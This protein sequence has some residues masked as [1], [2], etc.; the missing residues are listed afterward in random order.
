M[1]GLV[2]LALLLSI[3]QDLPPG[4]PGPRDTDINAWSFDIRNEGEQVVTFLS[5]NV[6]VKRVDFH[7]TAERAMV[8]MREGSKPPLEEIYAEGNVVYSNGDQELRAERLYFNF[9]ESK[10]YIVEL[11][12]RAYSEEYKQTLYLTASEARMVRRGKF[13]ARDVKL[14][15]CDY[16]I[17][18]YHLGIDRASLTGRDEY[19]TD[20]PMILWPYKSW[21]IRM[22]EILPEI[23]GG[24]PI[25]FIPGLVVG[26]WVKDFPVR[27]VRYGRTSRFGSTVL[28]EMERRL[29]IRDKE[30]K[31]R[32]WGKIRGQADWREK[33][34]GGFGLDL[35][36]AWG[37]YSGFIDTYFLHD[38]GRDPDVSFNLK[39]PPLPRPE[40]GRARL[41]HRHELG[42]QWRV[43]VEA[44]YLT[45]RSLLEEFFEKEF[46][47]GKVPETAGYVRWLDGGAGAYLYER[48]RLNDFQTQNE[49]LPRAI[50]TML[51][52]P[53]GGG[54]A[55]NFL[56]TTRVE[57]SHLRRRHDKELHIPSRRQWRGDLLTEISLPWDLDI[58][59]FMPFI[60]QRLTLFEDDLQGET[61]FRSLWST[62]ARLFAQLHGTFPDVSWDLVGLDGLRHVVD[63]DIRYANTVDNNVPRSTLFRFDE[64][65][66][67]GEFEEAAFGMRHRFQTR[68]EHGQ[69]FEFFSIWGEV[70][71]YPD[72]DR[73]TR[74]ANPNSYMTPFHWILVTP[75][76][77]TGT[78]PRRHWSNI[79]WGAAF[80]PRNRLQFGIGGEYNPVS[81]HEETR[82]MGVT[83]MPWDDV[84]ASVSHAFVRGLTDAWNVS[85]SLRMTE[86][87]SAGGSFQYDFQSDEVINQALVFSRDYHDFLIQVVMERDLGRDE[88]RVYVS[89][90]PK[91]LGGN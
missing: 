56:V 61:G 4:V 43:E 81:G 69:S 75:E 39:F 89:F 52:R 60:Q 15:T 30:G 28:S 88:R 35:E 34:G 42:E 64:L 48:H 33:R 2:S 24:A 54:F 11:K 12:G 6:S 68:D 1:I 67:L 76:L 23:V 50:F 9:K 73:D 72:S 5:G 25:F 78:F 86:K 40:R 29:R 79:H 45:D 46:K 57:I 74:R 36:Y 14:T 84:Q 91:F 32:S 53:L 77:S 19:E 16:G 51:P 17:P 58:V 90:V 8:W 31:E 22:E 37:P 38:F 21:D 10:A 55:E 59:Q 63:L 18:H 26:S 70:E 27:S 62:G 85:A 44:S 65:E 66:D 71:F 87:W 49:Y 7:L 82:E 47:E 13:E 20:N 41:F 80:T 83:V 3:P